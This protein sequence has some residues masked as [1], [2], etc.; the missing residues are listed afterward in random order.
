[1]N[2]EKIVTISIVM[3]V[4]AVLVCLAS[5]FFSYRAYVNSQQ[6]AADYRN[7]L[8]A[9]KQSHALLEERVAGGS[10]T[11]GVA[12]SKQSVSNVPSSAPGK[13]GKPGPGQE[14]SVQRLEQIIN[15]TGLSIFIKGLSAGK[16]S[17]SKT[18][19]TAPPIVPSLRALIKSASLISGPLAVLITTAVGFI[20]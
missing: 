20:C 13:A 1:M 14:N 17:S 7:E 10:L 19:R 11:A 4:S 5:V 16:G 15:S 18:S 2:Q 9:L 6:L 3:A 12:D 8:T